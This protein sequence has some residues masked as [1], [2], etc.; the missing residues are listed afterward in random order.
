VG[1][2]T[3]PPTDCFYKITEWETEKIEE[4]KTGM[5]EIKKA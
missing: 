5:G 2:S 1:L 4:R 3:G